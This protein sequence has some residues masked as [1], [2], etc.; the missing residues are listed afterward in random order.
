[1]A[2]NVTDLNVLSFNARSAV[3]KAPEIGNF[4]QHSIDI[5]LIQETFLKPNIPFKIPNYSIYRSDRPQI[6]GGGCAIIIKNSIQHH[7]VIN[8]TSNIEN[9]TV[10]VNFADQLV[11]FI[12]VYKPPNVALTNTSMETLF[13]RYDCYFAAG[14]FNFKDPLWN[15]RVGNPEGSKLK[16]FLQ[17]NLEINIHAPSE[18]THQARHSADILD[19]GFSKGLDHAIDVKVK[20]DLNS[21]HWPVIFQIYACCYISAEF[22]EHITKKQIDFAKFKSLL[23]DKDYTEPI[24]PPEI[25]SF[26]LE[27][28]ND[29]TSAIAGSKKY[30]N[31]LKPVDN[32]LPVHIRDLIKQKNRLRKQFYRYRLPSTKNAINKIT[33]EIRNAI[34]EHRSNTWDNFVDQNTDLNDFYKI[35]RYLTHKKPRIPVLKEGDLL[36]QSPDEKAELFAD[37]LARKYTSNESTGADLQA[38]SETVEQEIDTM[39][40]DNDAPE[41]TPDALNEYI[42]QL[43]TKSAP[44]HD[45]IPNYILKALPINIITQ[46]A[47]IYSASIRLSYFPAGWKTSRLIVIPKPNKDPTK[48]ANY[49]PIHLLTTMSKLLEYVIK[50]HLVKF[51]TDNNILPDFQFGFREELSTTLQVLRLAN[52]IRDAF[53]LKRE[54]TLVLLD[55]ESAFDKVNHRLLLI[56]LIQIGA[57]KFLIKWLKSYLSNRKF[58]IKLDGSRPHT[59]RAW[60]GVPQGSVL[61]PILFNIIMCHLPSPTDHRIK[62]FQ[63]ADDIAILC[64]CLGWLLT[65]LLQAQLDDT[66]TYLRRWGLDVNAS[67]TEPV[68][69][70]TRTKFKTTPSPLKVDGKYIEFKTQAKY[71]GV[72]LDHTLHF[73]PHLEEILRKTRQRVAQLAPIMKVDIIN[74][75]IKIKMFKTYIRPIFSYASPAWITSITKFSH[76][77]Q[78][79]Q[80]RFIR[81]AYH[82]PKHTHIDTMH[83]VASIELVKDYFNR[84][85]ERFALRMQYIENPLIAELF[86]YHEGRHKYQKTM[87]LLQDLLPP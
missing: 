83:N 4:L 32:T 87:K 42:K 16:Q 14:D 25:D 77:F 7:E 79:L 38:Q 39:E 47:K 69:F 43:K 23:E 10:A 70:S 3:A 18:P 45:N 52:S 78:L 56:K 24:S 17:D 13:G 54:A 53:S 67:K 41:I 72:T 31:S 21:D 29:I 8:I 33:R 61:G 37:V 12:S 9:C 15:S 84:L 11:Y 76:E 46:L 58:F 80:N 36:A 82:L 48:A 35:P 59:R 20:H 85:N 60:A 57:P 40:C 22:K 51:L 26:T 86:A 1:M 19:L 6:I 30:T 73:G 66:I 27:L 74:P 50:D 5:A 34:A 62:L 2:N 44:G 71:L 49:R 81:W 68:L 64:I 75:D 55:V 63:Y 65:V 28:E